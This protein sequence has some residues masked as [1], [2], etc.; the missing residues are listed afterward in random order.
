MRR[1]IFRKRSDELSSRRKT[2]GGIHEQHHLVPIE[3]CFWS[4][5]NSGTSRSETLNVQTFGLGA[6]QRFSNNST[7]IE[8]E[9]ASYHSCRTPSN[10]N[11]PYQLSTDDGSCSQTSYDLWD[12][13]ASPSFDFRA[14][15]TSNTAPRPSPA[16][17]SPTTPRTPSSQKTPPALD[18][19]QSTQKT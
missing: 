10:T 12:N 16:V 13:V 5:L 19:P 11:A 2:G 15:A 1:Y 6:Q 3:E 18:D 8:S 7:C 14:H 4:A 17:R 9:S